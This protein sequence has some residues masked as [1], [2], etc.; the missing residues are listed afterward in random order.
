MNWLGLPVAFALAGSV[1]AAF[2]DAFRHH[3]DA[4]A[5]P[6]GE[7]PADPD[8]ALRARDQA[9]VGA[10]DPRAAGATGGPK[11]WLLRRAARRRWRWVGRV[12]QVHQRYGELRGNDLA[13]S[14]TL[15]SF[16][17][18]FPLLLVA[19]AVLGFL[20]TNSADFTE[21]VIDNLGLTGDAAKNVTE[22][23]QTASDSRKAST[24]IGLLGLAWAGLALTNALRSAYNRAWQVQDHGLKGRAFGVLWLVGAA[25]IFLASIAVTTVVRFLP[26]FFAPLGILVG[27]A[28]SFALFLW[29]EHTLADV[30]VGWRPLVPGAV[31]GALGL[32]VLKA[33][34]AF[35][36]PN[37]VASS[38]ALYGTLGI[39]FA[40]LAW[41]LFL[42]RLVVY[43]AVVNVVLYEGKRGTV[44]SAVQVPRHAAA[45][46]E[47]NRSGLAQPAAR[48]A[49]VDA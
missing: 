7:H 11:G 23:L 42:G 16:L 32:E 24:V 22:A 18:L 48:K 44:T 36:V 34:G 13:A 37:M 10:F 30:D 41:L 1:V 2:L 49:A 26:G 15:Q 28:V 6:P 38:S 8:E 43:T 12:L 20:N 4:E 27:I 25:V 5:A 21:K 31:L 46:R 40:I 17:A 47:T 35:L 29:T 3:R 14:V 45:T 9:S 19:I 39:V 33:L